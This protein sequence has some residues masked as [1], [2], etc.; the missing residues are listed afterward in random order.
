VFTALIVIGAVVALLPGNLITLLINTQILNGLI[1]PI[2]LVFILVLANRRAVLG[3]HVNG[4]RYRVVATAC[5]LVIG[6]LA[7]WVTATTI[8]GWFGIG[9]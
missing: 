2:V 1:S 6:L 3:V 9:S 7:V 5:V 8:A 4:P